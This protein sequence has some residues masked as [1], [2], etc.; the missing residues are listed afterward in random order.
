MKVMLRSNGF[1]GHRARA[2]ARAKKIDR[3]EQIAKEITLNFAD[4][5]DMVS[6]LTEQRIKLLHKVRE[7]R[8]SISALALALH[9]DPKSV[10]RDVEKLREFGVVR[11]CVEANPG[12]G[13]V[14]IVEP[15]ARTIALHATL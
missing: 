15:V 1:E 9:R 4:P 8:L 14:S 12:H 10:R 5:L 7:E 2:R 11:T 13:R 3:G 6:V